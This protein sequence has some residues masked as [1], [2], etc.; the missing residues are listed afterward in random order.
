MMV[1]GLFELDLHNVG[2]V[3]DSNFVTFVELSIFESKLGNTSRCLLGDQLD[4]LND[5]INNLTNIP[6]LIKPPL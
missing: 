3:D 5:S 1:R 6:E 2:L 4:T